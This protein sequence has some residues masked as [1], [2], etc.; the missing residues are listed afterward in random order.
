MFGENIHVPA[1]FT[2]G[3]RL[4]M[5]FGADISS[6]IYDDLRSLDLSR[7]R[8][9]RGKFLS[10]VSGAD[11]RS[12]RGRVGCGAI[13]CR[14]VHCSCYHT[15]GYPIP[16]RY[17]Y[18]YFYGYMDDPRLPKVPR[19]P[20]ESQGAPV[21]VGEW[22]QQSYLGVLNTTLQ[23][24]RSYESRARLRG[25]KFSE[26]PWFHAIAKSGDS[27][28]FW[29]HLG[30]QRPEAPGRGSTGPLVRSPVMGREGEISNMFLP[31]YHV[32]QSSRAS[33]INTE[34]ITNEGE[35]L[36]QDRW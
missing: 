22:L 3:F 9:N 34:S 8:Q 23:F 28:V 5:R 33:H 18:G 30:S 2:Q 21:H 1:M 11:P 24:N 17:F 7:P 20:K 4:L 19:S 6:Q 13:F 27:S 12:Q 16:L 31:C 25:A 32:G 26:I 15:G 10:S 29:C 14:W 36:V 35:A